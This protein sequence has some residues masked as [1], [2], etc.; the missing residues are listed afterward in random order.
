MICE[1]WRGCCI[2][3]QLGGYVIQVILK[4]QKLGSGFRKSLHGFKKVPF[5]LSAIADWHL[6]YSQILAENY[7]SERVRVLQVHGFQMGYHLFCISLVSFLLPTP[8][9]FFLS[10]VLF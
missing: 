4:D 9:D 1:E 8:S 2:L 3:P 10:P 7:T 6:D 5:D